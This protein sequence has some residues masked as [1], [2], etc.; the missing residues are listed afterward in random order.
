MFALFALL[1]FVSNTACN[2]NFTIP[3]LVFVTPLYFAY[4][5]YIVRFSSVMF[6]SGAC[7][8]ATP[9]FLATPS[10][11]ATPFFLAMP[12]LLATPLATSNGEKIKTENQG[13]VLFLKLVFLLFG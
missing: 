1:P 7:T 6:L 10:F 9:F 12:S 3:Y 11:L 5:S 2:I 4:V 8:Q 13:K